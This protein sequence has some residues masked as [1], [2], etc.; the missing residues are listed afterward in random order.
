MFFTFAFRDFVL[1][2]VAA[3]ELKARAMARLGEAA[4]W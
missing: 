1:D 4:G 2:P 3:E